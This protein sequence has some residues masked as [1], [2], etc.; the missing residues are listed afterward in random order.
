MFSRISHSQQSRWGWLASGPLDPPSWRQDD[1]CFSPGIGTLSQLLWPFRGNWEGHHTISQLPQHSWVHLDESF[2]LVYVQLKCSPTSSSS[3]NG[4]LSL[5]WTSPIVCGAWDSWE[6]V[7]PVALH[8]TPHIHF[9]RSL[10]YFTPTLHD[11]TAFLNS[12]VS[13]APAAIFLLQLSL[14]GSSLLL[15]AGFLPPP[16]YSIG[17]FF[18]LEEVIP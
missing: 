16:A 13:P 1:I 9:R 15:F 2:R 18:S 17:P 7:L 6:S 10:A 5:C 12:C 8:I 3:I 4:M 11:Q 14:L